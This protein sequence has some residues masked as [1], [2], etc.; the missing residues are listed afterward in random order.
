MN[1]DRRE[2]ALKFRVGVFVLV[3]LAAFLGLVYA[4]GARARLFEARYVI[5]ADFTE[6]GGLIEGATVRLAGVQIGRVTGVH[7]PGE[8]GGRVRVDLDITRRYADRIRKDSIARIE[9]QGLLGAK[10]VEI[11]GGT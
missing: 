5:Y 3:A 11:N 8:P 9:K 1:E 4:L 6:V 2:T 7:L 10:V